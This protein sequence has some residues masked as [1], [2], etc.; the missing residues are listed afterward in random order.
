MS[1]FKFKVIEGG[2]ADSPEDT[3]INTDH[4]DT[5]NESFYT[6]GTDVEFE[7]GW[8]TDTRLM[9]VVSMYVCWRFDKE[10]T[11]R[12]LHQF[13]YFD[14]AEYGFDRFEYLVDG[15]RGEVEDIRNTFIGGLGGNTVPVSEPDAIHLVHEYAEY[16]RRAGIPLP[17]GAEAYQFMLDWP[18]LLTDKGRRALFHKS[19]APIR[20][21]RMAVNYFL[22]RLCDKDHPGA[23]YMSEETADKTIFAY[24]PAMAL[25]KNELEETAD[26]SLLC[27]TVVGYGE[28]SDY[29]YL[30]IISTMKTVS[31]TADD[32]EQ[33]AV[34]GFTVSEVNVESAMQLSDRE[35]YMNLLHE[36]YLSVFHYS[37]SPDDFGRHSTELTKRSMIMEEAHGR[38]FMIYNSNNDHV[39]SDCYHLYDDLLGTY[40]LLENGQL[41]STANT[42]ASKL[43]LDYDLLLTGPADRI[44]IR[45]SYLFNEPVLN[46]FIQSGY[47]DFDL[48][49]NDVRRD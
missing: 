48:F 39:D 11:H 14:V 26:G 16:N 31:H 25:Y 17:D 15:T 32:C 46:A 36:E 9:G 12:K 41:I 13:F 3:E 2:L 45:N 6:D 23:S 40:Y 29:R 10:S 43:R 19:C 42:K 8:I 30:L 44:R 27:K 49:L 18:D 20:T 1:A 34:P 37:G 38:L 22:M 24:F 4:A 33:N 7:Y 28:R 35:A 21:P 47:D 5:V